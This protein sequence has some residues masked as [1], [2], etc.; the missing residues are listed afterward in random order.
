MLTGDAASNQTGEKTAEQAYKNIKVLDGMPASKLLGAMD[1]MSAALG[2]NC[3]HCH[4]EE[5]ESDVK[6][7]KEA[8]RKM[9]VMT[10]SLNKQ[11]F[12]GYDVVSCYTCHRGRP[13]T[14]GAIPQEEIDF[15]LA[16]RRIE[17]APPGTPRPGKLPPADRIV[18]DYV[19][20]IGG[21]AA[22]NKLTSLVSKGAMTAIAADG[23]PSNTPIE[24]RR[25]A[26]DKLLIV[27]GRTVRGYDGK[28][29]WAKDAVK[30]RPETRELD[31]DEL[32]D[33][34]RDADFYRYLKMKESYARMG[35]LGKEKVGGRDA[36]VIGASGHDGRRE[37]LY[38]DV[39]RGLLIRRSSIYRTVMGAIPE[40][41]DFDDYR[42]VGGVKLPF[43]VRWT[44]PP[45][46][47]TS[48]FTEIRINVPIESNRFSRP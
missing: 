39:E 41:I 43:M 17:P 40:V 6:P 29:A 1:Y 9:I 23:P 13:N 32:A 42:D 27:T 20:A 21:E 26:P 11:S 30:A 4:T 7:A 16:A 44:R 19:R 33:V 5:W 22:I 45:F 47:A 38:F 12:S 2:V 24:I 15:W 25:R 37:R 8:T 34:K 18:S 10:R 14:E 48:R 36:Y 35:L 46:S 28:T 3:S 31:G